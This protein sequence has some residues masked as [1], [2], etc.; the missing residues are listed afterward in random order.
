LTVGVLASNFWWRQAGHTPPVPN[1][2]H[3]WPQL[4]DQQSSLPGAAVVLC[5]DRFESVCHLQV[6]LGLSFANS[7]QALRCFA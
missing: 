6:M 2:F 7:K 3:S 5:N 1:V 4:Q